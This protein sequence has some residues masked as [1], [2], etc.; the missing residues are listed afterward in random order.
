MDM[1]ISAVTEECKIQHKKWRDTRLG[2]RS[3]GVI[4]LVNQVCYRTRTI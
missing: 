4:F 3:I 1:G 2:K